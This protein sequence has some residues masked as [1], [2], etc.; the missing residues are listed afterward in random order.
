MGQNDQMQEANGLTTAANVWAI[1][2]VGVA[3]ALGFYV[4]AIGSTL[5]LYLMLSINNFP[6]YR[7]WRKK[8]QS[9]EADHKKEL[10]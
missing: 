2:A 1:S 5:L 4:I 6:T 8:I 10:K 3:V 9:E 7:K